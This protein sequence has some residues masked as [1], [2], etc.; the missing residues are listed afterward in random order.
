MFLEVPSVDWDDDLGHVIID[1]NDL[2]SR[3]I[4]SLYAVISASRLQWNQRCL[5]TSVSSLSHAQH[6]MNDAS[7]L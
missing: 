6:L 5:T 1:G 2:G 3:G 7:V 4:K